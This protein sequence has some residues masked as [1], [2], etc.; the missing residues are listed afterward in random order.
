MFSEQTVGVVHSFK[1][2]S[3]MKIYWISWM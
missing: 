3:C 2:G 1:V